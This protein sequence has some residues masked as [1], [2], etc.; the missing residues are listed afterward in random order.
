MDRYLVT[1]SLGPVQS[2]IGAARRTRDLWCGSWLLSEA[3]RA[4]ARILHEHQPGCLI[5]PH[6]KDPA[7]DLEPQDRPGD[8]ANIANILRAEIALP[9]TAAVRTLC[10]E[11]K[12]A[13]ASRI[14]TLGDSARSKV[15]SRGKSLREDVWLAQIDDILETHSAWVLIPADGSYRQASKRLGSALAARKATRNFRACK[16]LSEGWL[17]KSSLDGARETV[18]QVLPNGGMTRRKLGLSGGEQLDA[19]GFI[20]RLAGDPEQFTAIAR[21]AADSWIECLSVEQQMALHNAYE[22]LVELGRATRTR[23]NE[24]IYKALPFDAM[25]LYEFRLK[26]PLS[27]ASDESEL[28]ALQQ[29]Q[30]CIKQISGETAPSGE[31]VR[32]PVP[33]VAVLKA[34]GDRMGALL[35]AAENADRARAISG[36]LHGFASDVRKIVRT[37]RGH[38]VYAGGDDVLALLPLSQARECSEALACAFA[39]SLGGI[40]REMGIPES[41]HPT[42]SVGLGI[43][44]IMQPMGELRARSEWAE[45]MAKGDA[46]KTPRNALAIILGIRSGAEVSWRGTWSDTQAFKAL[47]RMIS[48]YHDGTLPTRVAYEIRDID[49]RLAWLRDDHSDRARGIQGAEV[50]RML[51]RARVKGGAKRIPDDIRDLI[52]QRAQAQTLKGLAEALIVAR[53]LS[54][55]TESDVGE[56]T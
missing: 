40:A 25:L 9:D 42:L 7:A 35:S 27:Q 4:A 2:L 13:A 12:A 46:T 43:S 31:R 21:I 26:N 51:L 14:A 16:P 3:A 50:D 6:L 30:R 17:P 39:K 44:H 38:A 47:D 5:F 48:A 49:R 41:E 32:A 33:Y 8:S 54:A 37:H 23:G 24:G 20:K 15:D 1:L 56:R 45:R 22:P 19:L 52:V 36:K 18:L 34:D 11:A 29:L 55:R 53:W 28:R 10:E